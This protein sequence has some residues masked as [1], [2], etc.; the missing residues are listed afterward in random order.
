M[1]DYKVLIT[2]SGTGSRLGERTKNKNKALLEINGHSTIDYIF[3][4]YPKDVKFVITLGYLADQVKNFLTTNYPNRNLEFARVDRFEGPG[5]SLVYSML[6]ARNLL[7]CPFIFH[8]CDTIVVEPISAPMKNWIAGYVVDE[9]K[10]ELELSQYRTHEVK[11]KQ[12]LKLKD[13]GVPGFQSIHIGLDG[14]F[15][16]ENFWKIA[17]T[18]YQSDPSNSTWSEVHV[19]DEMI[20]QG[21]A[22]EWIPYKVWLDT[23]S[24]EALKKTQKYFKNKNYP[25]TQQVN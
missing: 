1:N 17:N 2:T 22:F 9:Q 19:L 6:Q 15:D 11:N 18:L 20:K 23:G 21:I 8:A 25:H 4:K 7:K 5:S 24:V 12:I 3:D 10:S 13:K 16:Y 14:I